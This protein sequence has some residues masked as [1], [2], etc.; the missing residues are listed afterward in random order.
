MLAYLRDKL[1]AVFSFIVPTWL[2]T[3]L[4]RCWHGRRF[5][6]FDAKVSDKA[7]EGLLHAMA[8]GILLF[9]DWRKRMQGF[10]GTLVFAARASQDPKR[11]PVQAT[12]KFDGKRM[13]VLKEAAK[14][15][16][17]KVTFSEPLELF[18]FVASRKHDIVEALLKNAV[19]TQGNINYV[20]RFGFLVMEMTRWMRAVV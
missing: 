17:V 16:D 10:Q 8:W 7:L 19:D 12:A 20:Y 6:I 5:D 11:E 15:F 3:F 4:F 13:I 2:A 9:P 1:I 14:S 18:R